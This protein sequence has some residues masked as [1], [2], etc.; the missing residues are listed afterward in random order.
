MSSVIHRYR[1]FDFGSAFA[2]NDSASP[3]ILSGAQAKSKDLSIGFSGDIYACQKALECMGFNDAFSK[4]AW[5]SLAA[6]LP[7]ARARTTS[8]WPVRMSPAEKRLPRR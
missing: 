8:D 7:S 5:I 4:Y 1:F 3:V 6:A 2:Q